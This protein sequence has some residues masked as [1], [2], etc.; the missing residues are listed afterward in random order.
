MSVREGK[1]VDVVI[2][3][4]FPGYTIAL[5]A[6]VD[7]TDAAINEAVDRFGRS[8]GRQKA[9]QDLTEALVDLWS[10]KQTIADMP[11]TILDYRVERAKLRAGT[12]A[13]MHED[14][15]ASGRR[16]DLSMNKK[17]REAMAAFDA[18]TDAEVAKYDAIAEREAAKIPE[19]E[20][21]IERARQVIGGADRNEA[22]EHDIALLDG[23]SV[24]AE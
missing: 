15:A 7:D 11:K 19:L 8:F 21:R 13:R 9:K 24:A 14:H 18:S 10:A 6:S 1:Q 5:S 16:V 20:G 3:G 17:A 23:H 4:E 12:M 22:V 2:Q